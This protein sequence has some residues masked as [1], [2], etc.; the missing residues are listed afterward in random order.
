MATPLSSPPLHP[1]PSYLSGSTSIGPLCW[2]H[3]AAFTNYSCPHPPM[4]HVVPIAEIYGSDMQAV[5]IGTISHKILVKLSI[6]KSVVT[7]HI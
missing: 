6:A 4:V 1:L 5:A 7:C 2:L 3:L